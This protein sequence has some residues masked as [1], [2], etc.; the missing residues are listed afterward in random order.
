MRYI[1]GFPSWAPV[2][3]PEVGEVN[4]EASTTE[5]GHKIITV[6]LV[7]KAT[8]DLARTHG[9]TE[10]SQTDIVNRA[11]S[12]YEFLDQERGQRNRST[13]LRR[14]RLL[15]EHLFLEPIQRLLDGDDARCEVEVLPPEAKQLA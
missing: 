4:M 3:E 12:L 9:R 10:L 7:S 14:L 11:I 15:E 1:A 6:V 13:S 2:D 5:T 8:G